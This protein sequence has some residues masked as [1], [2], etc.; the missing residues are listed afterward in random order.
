MTNW[1]R[2]LNIAD[3]WAQAED[4][5]ITPKQLAHAIADRLEGLKPLNNLILE[6]EKQDIVEEFRGFVGEETF[7]DLDDVMEMLYD[8][9]DTPLDNKF[10]GKKVCWVKTF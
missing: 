9:A 4:R 8:W 5:E 2:T 6:N 1:Q 10:N 7:D 3:V